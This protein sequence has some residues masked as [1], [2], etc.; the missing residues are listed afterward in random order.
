MQ[1]VNQAGREQRGFK[2]IREMNL[3]VGSGKKTLSGKMRSQLTLV[4][5]QS[6]RDDRL[7]EIVVEWPEYG[8][9]EVK[10]CRTFKSVLPPADGF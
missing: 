2:P 6:A 5:R 4:M 1:S 9:L 7:G 3:I 8:L 10:D